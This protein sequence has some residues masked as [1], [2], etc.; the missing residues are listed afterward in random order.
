[1]D[2]HHR[3]IELQTP[4][5][6]SYLITNVLSAATQ[7]IDRDLP[8]TEGEDPFRRRVETLV[9]QYISDVFVASSGMDVDAETVKGMLEGGD[10]T[11]REVEEWE[12]FDVRKWERAKELARMEEDLVEEIAALRKGVPTSVVESVKSNYKSGVEGDEAELARRDAVREEDVDIG[13]RELERQ[14]QTEKGWK[15]GVEG[16]GRLKRTMPEMVAK[17]ERAREA[18]RYVVGK[19]GK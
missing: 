2:T 18:E 12:A 9:H 5:D 17:A 4:D 19:E 16:L 6:L 7:K 11:V 10:G 15:R 14:E 1:M 3:K 8:A 13:V